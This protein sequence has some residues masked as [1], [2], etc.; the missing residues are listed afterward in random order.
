[1][2]TVNEQLI[3]ELSI[4]FSALTVLLAAIG[5]YGVMSYSV[6]RRTHEIGIRIALGAPNATVLWM[7]LRESLA[8]LMIGLVVGI[9]AALAAARLVQSQLFGLSAFDPVTII[10]AVTM[11]A[12]VTLVA[13]WLPARK[14]AGVDP[15]VA[16]RCE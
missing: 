5:L 4:I 8:L 11:I 15:L 16:L 13:A 1:M 6:L 2:F 3:S 10:S 7:V 9:P 14:A 12:V